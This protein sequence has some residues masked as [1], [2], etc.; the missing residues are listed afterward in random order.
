M[1]RYAIHGIPE[2]LGYIVAGM[3]GG[4]ISVAVIRHDFR[5]RN[6]ERVILDAS[7]LILLAVFIIFI[8]ALLEVFV[9]PLFF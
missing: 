8:A 4:L 9:T 5:T 2:I 3:A 7:D 1:L 6:F